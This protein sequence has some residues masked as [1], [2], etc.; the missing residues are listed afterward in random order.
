M[1]D[2]QSDHCGCGACDVTVEEPIDPFQRLANAIAH[3]DLVQQDITSLDEL[4]SVTMT[5]LNVKRHERKL[6][7]QEFKDAM[8]AYLDS[9]SPAFLGRS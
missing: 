1:S 7:I 4:L 3:V 2:N 9:I 5:D 6:A 8:N